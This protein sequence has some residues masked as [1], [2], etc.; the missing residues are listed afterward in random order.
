LFM[1]DAGLD[2]QALRSRY[3]DSSRYIIMRAL[4]YP[5]LRGNKDESKWWGTISKLVVDHVNVP[6]EHRNTLGNL[7]VFPGGSDK[8]LPP[9]Y[10]AVLAFGKRAEPW[11]LSTRGL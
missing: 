11:V 9:R 8:A 6:L 7:D 4:V 5:H 3:P 1:V 10:A 2:M